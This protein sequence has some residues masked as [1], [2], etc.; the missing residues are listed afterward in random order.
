MIN[1]KHFCEIRNETLEQDR[2]NRIDNN[3]FII[4][5]YANPLITKFTTLSKIRLSLSLSLSTS[6]LMDY[7][8]NGS[9]NI[10]LFNKFFVTAIYG[11]FVFS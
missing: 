4:Y 3:I 8:E 2:N 5:L 1:I 11:D 6:I 9:F 10:I 7:Y